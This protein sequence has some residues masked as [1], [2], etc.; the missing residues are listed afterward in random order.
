MSDSL[1]NPE[2]GARL[3]NRIRA[4]G[5]I[6][7]AEFMEAALYDPDDGFY[8]RPPVGRHRHFVTSPHVS[9]AFAD[10]LARQLAECWEH[11]GRPDPFMVAEAG[12]GD[13]TLARGLLRALEAAPPLAEATRYVAIERSPGAR[14]ALGDAGIESFVRLPAAISGVILANELLDNLPFH[15]LRERNG[16]TVEVFVGASKD[17]RLKEVEAEPAPGAL[18]ALTEPLAPGE[19][20]AVSPATLA[21][22][23]EAGAALERGYLFLW[24]YAREPGTRAAPHAYRDHAVDDD[25]LAE[26]GS[27]DLTAAVDLGA[28][29]AEAGR[30]GLTTWPPVT[31]R[32]AL[33]ALGFRLW[34]S[35]ARHRQAE[36]EQRGD[37][38][39]A[40]RLYAARSEAT[41]LIDEGKL[42]GLMLLAAATE[43]LPPPAAVLGD[44]DR[45]C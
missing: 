38:R 31:Q 41:L 28:I 15:R 40:T 33:L 42:G 35:G 25:L 5:P 30:A 36:A 23:R 44:R 17:D 1:A 13:G 32:E 27:R 43:G 19:E 6:T 26:P 29:A 11:L 21:W 22:T 4:E 12:A 24:D 14:K 10:L 3:V 16:G 18:A 39:E 8:A 34:T 9:P 2:L 7:F 20:R 45:G 37:H